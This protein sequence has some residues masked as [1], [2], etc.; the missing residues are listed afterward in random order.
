MNKCFSCKQTFLAKDGYLR[1]NKVGG[2]KKYFQCKGCNTARAKRYR[3]TDEGRIKINNAIKKTISKLKYKQL[4][5]IAIAK[6]VR[7]GII[8]KPI[9]CQICNAIGKLEAHHS[10]YEKQLSVIWT[11]KNC[12]SNIHRTKSVL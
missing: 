12:H 8:K 2:E 10:D 4:A 5:R 9:S 3:A 1:A 7:Q 11:C 6:A